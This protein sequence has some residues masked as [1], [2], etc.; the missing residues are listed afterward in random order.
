M[1]IATQIAYQLLQSVLVVLIA[2][3]VAGW[4][5]QCRAWLTVVTGH[6]DS[7]DSAARQVHPST[8]PATPSS[9]SSI[10]PSGPADA[11]RD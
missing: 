8:V 2:P 9:S 6:C 4:V 11:S 7:H 10:S 5:N 1:N 3:A